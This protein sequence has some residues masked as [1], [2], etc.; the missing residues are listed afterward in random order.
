MDAAPAD[1]RRVGSTGRT[2]SSQ[3]DADPRG[4][5]VAAVLI[6][7]LCSVAL[8]P[9]TI[10]LV[11]EVLHMGCGTYPP[12][13]EGAGTWTCADGIGYISVAAALGTLWLVTSLV[14]ALLAG[15]VRPALTARIGLVV[16]AF[17][18]TGAVLAWFWSNT[19]QLV[20]DEHSPLSASQLWLQAVGPAALVSAAAL[21]VAA[22]SLWWRGRAAVAISAA[23]AGLMVVAIMLQ[24]GLGFSLL[25]VAGLLAAASA[26]SW[27]PGMPRRDRTAAASADSS[28]AG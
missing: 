12:G 24:P 21:V 13:T 2:R 11:R 28:S 7:A 5:S 14:G 22:A 1:P 25:P 27:R 26:R 18:G 20:R 3:A 16:L 9:F 19:L 15:L 23:A 17:A 8:G 4:L 6:S 10:W